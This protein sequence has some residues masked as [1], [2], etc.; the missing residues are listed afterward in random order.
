MHFDYTTVTDDSVRR[1][2]DQAIERGED[3]VATIIQ[4]EGPRTWD[5]TLAA[6]NTLDDVIVRARGIG[7]FMAR[8]HPDREVRDAAQ[9]AE[10]KV[11]KWTSDLIFRRDLRDAVEIFATTDEAASLADERAR[12]LQFM[13]RDL[14]RAGHD[15]SEAAR[16]EVQQHRT[17]LVELGVAFNRNIDEAEGG[18]DLDRGQLAGMP[19]DYVARLSPG[20]A[21]ETYRVSIDY[22]DYYP[23]MDMATSRDLRQQLQFIF[24][25]KAVDENEP[26]LKE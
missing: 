8:V 20:T 10:E 21:D 5:N 23:F 13:Q 26:I 9:E 22:P 6:L 17:R 7:P 3:L 25:N 14:R 11:S 2:V 24:Y 15:L 16:A 1:A 4:V 12:Y 18:L 19:D